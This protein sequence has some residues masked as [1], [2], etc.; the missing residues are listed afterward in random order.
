MPTVLVAFAGVLALG[1]RACSQ[2]GTGD[3]SH[4]QCPPEY[5]PI[6]SQIEFSCAP[7]APD[8]GGCRYPGPWGDPNAVD[9]A[10]VES[11]YPL[12]CRVTYPMEHPAF[13]CM[14]ADCDCL[15]NPYFSDGAPHWSCPL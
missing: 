8:G 15:Q 1:T 3:P 13:E 2:G 5:P 9:G 7:S 11:R 12:G 10:A 6:P 14:P 4:K